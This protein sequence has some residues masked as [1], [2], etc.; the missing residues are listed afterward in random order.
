MATSS[1]TKDFTL[2]SKKAVDSFTK[3][4]A[5]PAKNHVKLDRTLTSPESKR[6][7]EVKLK[8]MLSR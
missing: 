3:I 2:D 1:F 4:I 8:Q 6:R 5:T 7:G